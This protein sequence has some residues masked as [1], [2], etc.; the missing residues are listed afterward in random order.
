MLRDDAIR[1]GKIEPTKEDRVRMGMEPIKPGPK[2]KEPK[3]K[4]VPKTGKK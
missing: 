1:Q 3:E 4:E 2:P